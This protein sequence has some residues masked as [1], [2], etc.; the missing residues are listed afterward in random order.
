[1]QT[2]ECDDVFVHDS[3]ES[4]FKRLA[5]LFETL[6]ENDEIFIVGLEFMLGNGDPTKKTEQTTE[7][8]PGKKAVDL[9]TAAKKKGVRVRLMV[10][11]EE[12]FFGEQHVRD[13]G[14]E[15]EHDSQGHHHQKAVYIQA[16]GTSYLLVGGMD[17]S[18]GFD[19]G[20]KRE[21]RLGFWFD[22][23][24]EIRGRAAELGK[25]TL[26]E[27]W[28][29]V[30]GSRFSGS[31]T[32]RK[33][34]THTFCQFVRTYPTDVPLAAPMARPRKYNADFSYGRLLSEAIRKASRFIYLED[35][36]FAQMDVPPGLDKLLIEAVNGRKV[37]LIVV[38]ARAN[39]IEPYPQSRR[40]PLVK[41]L[42]AEIP[43]KGRLSLLQLREAPPP[44]PYFVHTKAWIFDDQL[45]VVGSANYWN[46]SFDGG[47]TEFGVAI[48]STLSKAAFPGVPFAR[49]LRVRM[50]NRL[51]TAA[52]KPTI[53]LNKA[54]SLLDELAVLV[55]GL[56][57]ITP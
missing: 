30:R 28:A 52:G 23:Q 8:L 39:Q 2:S 19:K 42:F 9:L 40:G 5:Q 6:G 17:V 47:D 33:G 50:W 20:G 48:A 55:R 18:L 27:R 53:K 3:Y 32:P 22:G 56:E 31:F 24:A 49:A 36:Y 43:Q 12:P 21:P 41:T 13:S 15:V 37:R 10:T 16:K 45:A 11:G 35:Q 44:M 54:A 1:M 57:P 29:S 34:P 46:P 14:I 26:E 51:L 38:A 7:L 25:L 4:Y